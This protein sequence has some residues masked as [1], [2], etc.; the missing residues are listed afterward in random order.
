MKPT[1]TIGFI[2]A[3]VISPYLHAEQGLALTWKNKYGKWFA[4][5]PVQCT[6]SSNETEEKALS[7]VVN[8][9]KH[10]IQRTYQKYGK[11]NV[12]LLDNVESYEFDSEK[13]KR[14]SKC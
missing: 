12:Y 11:C 5:G 8:E 13:V 7:Y 14:L 3:I 9:R 6:W 2:L 1:L 4:C 10:S